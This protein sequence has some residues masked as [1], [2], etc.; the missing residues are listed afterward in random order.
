MS[1]YNEELTK[2]IR[3]VNARITTIQRIYG[4]DSQIYKRIMSV[5]SKASSEKVTRFKKKMF[6][7]SLRDLSRAENALRTVEN[8]QYLTKEGRKRIGEKARETFFINRE[9]EGYDENVI[10]QMYDLFQQSDKIGKLVEAGLSSSQLV[11]ELMSTIE[12][13][14]KDAVTLN[15]ILNNNF[16]DILGKMTGSTNEVRAQQALDYLNDLIIGNE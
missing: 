1:N 5:I 16:A 6:T 4:K 8:N 15:K 12:R 7:G 2:R 11:D 14:D 3:S 13:E 9:A 10:V